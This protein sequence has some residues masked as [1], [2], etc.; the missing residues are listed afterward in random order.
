MCG[1]SDGTDP[2]DA[3]F[4]L[5]STWKQTQGRVTR[6]YG[7]RGERYTAPEEGEGKGSCGWLR[8]HRS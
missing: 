3:Q 4:G 2:G 8:T 7:F 6:C 1:R 5:T